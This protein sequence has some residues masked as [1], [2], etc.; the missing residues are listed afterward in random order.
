MDG[1]ET[2][3]D[4][5]SSSDKGKEAKDKLVAP[6]SGKDKIPKKSIN[7]QK[8]TNAKNLIIQYEPSAPKEIIVEEKMRTDVSILSGETGAIVTP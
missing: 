1:E 4:Q 5:E 7:I 6:I 3:K 2:T 8:V